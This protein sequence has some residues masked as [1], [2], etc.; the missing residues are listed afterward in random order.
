MSAPGYDQLLIVQELD[1]R[2]DQLRH[3]HGHNSSRALL[4]ELGARRIG[5]Q[6][7]VDRI[8][9]EQHEIERHRKRVDD[10]VAGIVARRA[11]IE[12]KLYDGSVTGTKDLLAL[13]DESKMLAARQSATE[14]DELELMEQLESVDAA[15]LAARTIVEQTDQQITA[16][17]AELAVVL[18]DIERDAAQALADRTTSAAGVPA[19]LL[20]RY[21]HLRADMG[22]VA[23]A[24]LVSNS[25]SGCHLSMSAVAADRIK[26]LPDD[27]VVTCDSCGRI[28]IR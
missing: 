9:A 15:L 27:A 13:Q 12:K 19:E 8:A 2:L 23:I 14:D 22:G 11:E 1:T 6:S 26:K 28:L 5:E 17:E 3:R 21:D 20:A 18:A 10:D 25:C 4:A 7:E 16:A 24:R